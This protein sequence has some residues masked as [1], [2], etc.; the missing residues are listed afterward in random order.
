MALARSKDAKDSLIR[1][2]DSLLSERSRQLTE[3]SQLLGDAAAA[4]RMAAQI[5]QTLSNVR[6]QRNKRDTVEAEGSMPSTAAQLELADRKV[7]TLLARLNSS[8]ARVRRM[9]QDSTAHADMDA[10]TL[11]R[12]AEYERS[13]GDLRGTVQRQQEEIVVLTSRVDSMRREN[14]VLVARNDT[15][16][17]R[18][19]AL[20]AKA[21]SAY[22]IIGTES[23]LIERGIARKEGGTRVLFGRGKTLVPAR[24]LDPAS[25]RVVSKERDVTIEFPRADKSYRLISRHNLQ[26]TDNAAVRDARVK[27]ALRITN[28]EAFWSTS[29]Y[30]IFVEQ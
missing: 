11:A 2:K 30:L 15:M 4:A 22:V 12:L 29:K 7:K 20:L 13:I 10:A 18:N 27:G 28:P 3:Q 9:R 26:F 1:V 23:E 25:F 16:T 6:L 17:A 14:V 8:E 5:E 21:D 19:M 24:T